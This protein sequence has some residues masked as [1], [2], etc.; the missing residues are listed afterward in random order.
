MEINPVKL[1]R[2]LHEVRVV[3]GKL[4]NASPENMKEAESKI[5]AIFEEPKRLTRISKKRK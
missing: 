1:K 2:V 4:L 5:E 3:L